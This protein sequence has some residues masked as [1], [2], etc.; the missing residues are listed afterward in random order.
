MLSHLDIA[1]SHSPGDAVFGVL[2]NG[3]QLA[4]IKKPADLAGFS[5]GRRGIRTPGT[6]TRT[7]V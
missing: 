6:V 7:T 1:M 3:C 5:S 2:L 4:K